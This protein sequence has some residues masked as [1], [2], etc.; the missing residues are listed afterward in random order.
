[1][2]RGVCNRRVGIVASRGPNAGRC[3]G[4]RLGLALAQLRLRGKGI[5]LYFE[6]ARLDQQKDDPERLQAFRK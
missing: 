2:A 3:D 4:L 5:E 6:E 1:L